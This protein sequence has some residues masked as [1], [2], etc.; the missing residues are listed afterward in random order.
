[1]SLYGCPASFLPRPLTY[2]GRISYG[3][4]VYHL[5]CTVLVRRFLAPSLPGSSNP[6]LATFYGYVFPISATIGLAALSFPFFEQPF[7]KFKRNL[8]FVRSGA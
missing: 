5:L 6:F 1:M 7:V 4:Y 8:T 3:L 2:L